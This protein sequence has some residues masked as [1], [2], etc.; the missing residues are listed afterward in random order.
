MRELVFHI[1]KMKTKM[2]MIVWLVEV[3]APIP[4]AEGQAGLVGIAHEQVVLKRGPR[5]DP[6]GLQLLTS[7]MEALQEAGEHYFIHTAYFYQVSPQYHMACYKLLA[8]TSFKLPVKAPPASLMVNV[9]VLPEEGSVCLQDRTEPLP[10]T[11]L[12]GLHPR[13]KS[14]LGSS[15]LRS[16]RH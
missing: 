4:P 6:W 8:A 15:G 11:A 14:V 5:R 7:I 9:P 10:H 16:G 3:A 12:R 13:P 2:G 1:T